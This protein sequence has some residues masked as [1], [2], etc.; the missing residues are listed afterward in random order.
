[1]S[2]SDSGALAN[3]RLSEPNELLM[4]LART[5]PYYKRNRPHVCSFWVKGECRRGEECP[6]RHERPTDPDDPLADQNIKDRYYGLFFYSIFVFLLFM[7][8]FVGINDP[9]ADKLLKRAA[10]MPAL[11]PPEDKTITTLYIGNLGSL[12]EQDIR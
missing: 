3:G 1:M 8:L 4:R 10:A 5:A 7:I 11:P 2:R 12:T 6:Y 9:V